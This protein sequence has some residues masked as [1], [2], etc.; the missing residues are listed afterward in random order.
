MKL[1]VVGFLA[2]IP[3]LDTGSWDDPVEVL[4]H[5]RIAYDGNRGAF[6][7]GVIRFENLRARASRVLDNGEVE[8]SA[9]RVATGTYAFDGKL[10][11]LDFLYDVETTRAS[12]KTIGRDSFVTSVASFRVL[13][14]GNRVLKDLITLDG[15]QQKFDHVPQI[16]FKNSINTDLDFP[17]DLGPLAYDSRSLS[18]DVDE[19]LR[20]ESQLVRFDA[21]SEHAGRSV[22]Y[23]QIQW[24]QGLREYWIDLER[25]GV[26]LQIVDTKPKEDPS[27][28]RR[29]RHE[30]LR[31]IAGHGWLPMKRTYY[32]RRVNL[33]EEFTIKDASF[34]KPPASAFVLEFPERV[35]MVDQTKGLVHHI[36][37]NAWSLSNL[38]GPNSQGV[39]PYV[40]RSFE[41]APEMPQER[42]SAPTWLIAVAVIGLLLCVLVVIIVKS[43]GQRN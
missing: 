11:R 1:L 8:S 9:P 30:D 25:G 17:L 39:S 29:V 6:Q 40:V 35:R 38:P 12:T 31:L 28:Y 4:K 3:S 22:M 27:E 41:P 13:S 5:V 19:L 36:G 14:D 15:S 26:P 23:F 42:E 24:K 16:L 20:G 21:N 34:E 10:A 18:Y 43:R 7:Q 37:R 33:Y 2:W 32:S